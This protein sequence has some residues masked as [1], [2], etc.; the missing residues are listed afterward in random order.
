MKDA[1]GVVLDAVE[2]GLHNLVM[3]GNV[4]HQGET[5]SDGFFR[6]S[7][8]HFGMAHRGSS[9]SFH[10]TCLVLLVSLLKFKPTRTADKLRL[11]TGCL[12]SSHELKSKRAGAGRAPAGG[13]RGAEKLAG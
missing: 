2:D 8:V 6:V 13:T 10:V 4:K 5:A 11:G 1:Q 12:C 7:P 3:D 9:F